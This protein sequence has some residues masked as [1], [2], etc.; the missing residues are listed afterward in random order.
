MLGKYLKLN[1]VQLPNPQK[2]KESHDVVENSKET[3][4]GTTATIITRYDK[5]SVSVSY[6]CSSAFANQLYALSIKDTLTMQLKGDTKESRTVMIRDFEK[7]LESGS[8]R[9]ARTDGLWNIS[10]TIEEI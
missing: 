3:E 1:G 2:W 6:Q 7:S 8:E 5:L 10:F 4:A 9:T